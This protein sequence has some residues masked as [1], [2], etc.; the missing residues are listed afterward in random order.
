LGVRIVAAGSDN[1]LQHFVQLDVGALTTP[2]T[3]NGLAERMIQARHLPAPK[4]RHDL[5]HKQFVDSL[6]GPRETA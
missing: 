4:R 2:L 1:L 5:G 3:V 6:L